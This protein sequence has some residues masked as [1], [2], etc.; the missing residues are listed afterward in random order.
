[1]TDS[2]KISEK[3]GVGESRVGFVGEEARIT[4]K[5]DNLTVSARTV[6]ISHHAELD[7]DSEWY[8]NVH[9]GLFKKIFEDYFDPAH[10]ADI[11]MNVYITFDIPKNLLKEHVKLVCDKDGAYKYVINPK[12]GKLNKELLPKVREVND[13]D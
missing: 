13:G 2:K 6:G 4:S 7:S 11:E 9:C 1:M 8:L 3:Y 12:A 10:L 5:E